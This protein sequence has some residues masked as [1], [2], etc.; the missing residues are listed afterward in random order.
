VASLT[1]A[2]SDTPLP[3]NA[4]ALLEA[5]RRKTIDKDF[6]LFKFGHFGNLFVKVG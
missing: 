4:S 5:E 3:P 1:P 2:K 6:G